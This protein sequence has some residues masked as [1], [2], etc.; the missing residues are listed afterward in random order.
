MLSRALLD[1]DTDEELGG[2]RTVVL[3]PLRLVRAI[4]DSAVYRE[5]SI[6]SSAAL[7]LAKM[8]TIGARKLFSVPV[9]P[10]VVPVASM[11]IPAPPGASVSTWSNFVARLPPARVAS[12]TIGLIMSAATSAQKVAPVTTAALVRDG[13]PAATIATP[14]KRVARPSP[15]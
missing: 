15:I 4:S 6:L 3:S 12:V 2:C 14:T 10:P 11:C 1:K 5:Q 9:L 7:F 13:E 8:D